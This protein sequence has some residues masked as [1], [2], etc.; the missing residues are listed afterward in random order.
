MIARLICFLRGHQVSYDTAK[1]GTK[2]WRCV[3]CWRVKV[4]DVSDPRPVIRNTHPK[5]RV[6]RGGKVA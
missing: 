1:D 2:I 4:R 3:R 5:F 6:L